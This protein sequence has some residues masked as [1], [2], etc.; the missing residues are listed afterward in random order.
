M[1]RLSPLQPLV[2]F[3]LVMLGC[4]TALVSPVWAV[5]LSGT[6]ADQLEAERAGLTREWI[7]Q[8]PFESD[9]YRLN[10]VDVGQW[11]VVAQSDD[12]MIHAVRA[13]A[14]KQ[15]Q[16][17]APAV[18]S[19]LWSTS[20]G[21]PR[22]PIQPAGI[23]H[24]LVTTTRNMDCCGLDTRTGSI[25]WRR[26][27]PVTPSAGSLPVGDWVYTPLRDASVYRLPANPFRLS[28]KPAK[29]E[30]T[31]EDADSSSK[32]KQQASLDPVRINSHGIVE[33]LPA[34]YAGGAIWCTRNGHLTAIEQAEKG[35][36]RHEFH[37]R[38]Q[39]NGP[40]VVTGQTVFAATVT[41]EL[42]RFED[43]PGG[44]RLTWRTLL[45][46]RLHANQ[47]RPQLMLAG[48]TLL[49]SLDAVGIA[50]HD[51]TTGK[52]K[53]VASLPGDLLAVVGGRLWCYDPMN[54]L[55]ALSLTD[56]RPVAFLD[57]GPFTM[58]VTNRSTE[59]LILASPRGLLVSLGSRD[60]AG[61]IGQPQSDE[62]ADASAGEAVKESG[63]P[64]AAAEPMD[65]D[66][67]F[68]FFGS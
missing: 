37:L 65:G 44:L 66:D 19:L 38:Q 54:R 64:A 58:P 51:A 36:A 16:P 24:N 50:A 28:A 57:P 17:E 32:K 59:K 45:E 67:S 14:G 68:D 25:L 48:N 12:G 15:A 7:V 8:L 4:T 31:G 21:L 20:L 23:D 13:A 52:R 10:R 11:L 29:D 27:L 41:G 53:W 30:A 18:G 62:E 35:W 42:A 1:S 56:G 26:R 55:T 39:P 60:V 9:G 61:A 63:E 22:F 46:T 2:R 5:S 6:A 49:V 40:V 43:A 47:P 34:P 33:Q 3:S